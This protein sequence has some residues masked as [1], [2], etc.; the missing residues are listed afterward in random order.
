MRDDMG[1]IGKRD[2]GA[3]KQRKGRKKRYLGI[4]AEFF[5]DRE[6]P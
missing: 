5:D 3:K 4:Y 2:G 1:E 6:L